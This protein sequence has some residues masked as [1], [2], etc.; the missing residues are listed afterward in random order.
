MK[1]QIGWA[2]AAAFI[3]AVGTLYPL[4]KCLFSLKCG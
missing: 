2:I 1:I 4:I 3:A